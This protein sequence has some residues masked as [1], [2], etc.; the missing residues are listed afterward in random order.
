[1]IIGQRVRIKANPGRIGLFTGKEMNRNGKKLLQ[2]QFPDNIQYMADNELEI[3]NKD[4]HPLDM[5]KD[6]KLGRAKDLRQ[7]LT[8]IKLSGKLADLLYSMEISNT[9]F[10][11]YQ[12]KPVLKM[13]NAVSKGILIADEVGLGKTI[14]A[15]LIWM[16]LKT[17]FDYRRLMILCPKSLQEKWKL[18]LK[19]RFGINSEILDAKSLLNKLKAVK[20]GSRELDF[21][22]IGSIQALRPLKNWEDEVNTRAVNKLARF[23][24]DVQNE[25]PLI[26]FLIIDEAHHLRISA[27]GQ[28]IKKTTLLG[29]LLSEV[30]EHLVLLSAT[31][32]HLRNHDLYQ[33]LN[34]IDDATF[35]RP[36]VFT[37]I[38]EANKP[39]VALREKI[40]N[41]IINQGE[42]LNY[43]NVAKSNYLLSDSK[44]LEEFINHPPSDEE[45]KN[46]NSRTE[47]AYRLENI[48]LL[49]HI[50]TRTRRR[51]VN[52]LSITR[53]VYAVKITP[54]Y[55]EAEF[56]DT[57]TS[58]VRESLNNINNRSI[59]LVTPQRQMSSS[60]PAAICSWYNSI[61]TKNNDIDRLDD[62]ITNE[63]LGLDL[64]D[65]NFKPNRNIKELILASISK[66]DI[67]EFEKIDS[68]YKK[69]LEII[70]QINNQN[71]SEKFIIFSFFR[72]T[73]KYLSRRLNEDG[74]DNVIIMGGDEFNKEEIIEEFKNNP[75]IKVLISS[76]VSSEGVDLQ[77]CRYLIN[78]DLPWNPMKIEQRIGRIDRIGQSAK[79]ISIYNFFFED[80]IDSRIYNRLFERL[81]LFEHALG[82]LEPVLGEKVQKLT[83]E[84]LTGKLT[85]EE[86][87][88]KIEQTALALE[89]IKNLEENL[90]NEASS[91]VAYGDYIL[92]KVKAARE[93]NRMVSG[94]DLLLYVTD[95]VNLYFSGSEFYELN[96]DE[97]LYEV[98]LTNDLKNKLEDFIKENRLNIPTRLTRISSEP[99]LCK[100]INKLV[101]E[102]KSNYEIINQ[103]HPLVRFINLSLNNDEFRYNPAVSVKIK[104]AVLNI[105]LDEG[106]YVFLV[107]HWSFKGIRDIEKVSYC[108]VN[109]EKDELLTDLVSE[110]FINTVVNF[111]LD[112][113]EYKNEIDLQKAFNLVNNVCAVYLDKEYDKFKNNFK[114]ENDDK[115]DLQLKTIKIHIENQIKKFEKTKEKLFEKGKKSHA[116]GWETR[117][118]N[119][120]NRFER[121][122]S[123][124]N[125]KKVIKTEK[126]EICA[127]IIKIIN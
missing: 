47:I 9:D 120:K 59:V 36:E 32:V 107:Q 96:K 82:S 5:L 79:F 111:G 105:D 35:N 14:E 68:K 18:E 24:R 46:S 26:D 1:M 23:L 84:L 38:L 121:Q 91:L 20:E 98:N 64:D 60:I 55:K 117:I 71:H 67:K 86:E 44:Q 83:L 13:I 97:D 127:G 21:A 76:E 12:F 31:P 109:Y 113:L 80:T 50:L 75:E 25:E 89:N 63:D 15:A 11:A 99:V 85:A 106:I 70:K 22:I 114:N 112:W 4:E 16:E 52:E 119:L 103:F 57:I 53:R 61:N 87:N 6:G 48:N 43:I 58:I 29:Q 81:E 126:N 56:Y 34:L 8:H 19:N 37:H 78:Y 104:K 17:R 7:V 115:A 2:I 100:F 77:F 45:L 88:E 124:I 108:A 101:A 54:E 110:K 39:L 73:I 51:D 90:E 74:F 66:D 10:Y 72:E 92:N 118:N 42:F 69:L 40:L 28:G 33:L 3:L 41:K 30:S 116:K 27:P 95:F 102:Y 122:K 65:E 94:K 49:G 62:L 123:L 93:L 125:N